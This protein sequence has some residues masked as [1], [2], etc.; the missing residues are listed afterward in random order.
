MS[1]ILQLD[2]RRLPFEIVTP[3]KGT[4]HSWTQ[5]TVNTR[6]TALI[7]SP[8]QRIGHFVPK[9]VIKMVVLRSTGKK[10]HYDWSDRSLKPKVVI[11][12]T[13]GNDDIFELFRLH[14]GSE[15]P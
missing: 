12:I 15:T 2:T 8:L 9:R 11:L 1:L 7:E 4:P 14:G 6:I 5:T 3:H 10:S 13:N